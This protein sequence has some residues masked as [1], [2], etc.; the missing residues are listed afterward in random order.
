ML[1]T[2][3][4]ITGFYGPEH[5][6]NG[7]LMRTVLFD[8]DGVFGLYGQDLARGSNTQM[9]YLTKFIDAKYQRIIHVRNLQHKGSGPQAGNQKRL[10]FTLAGVSR[11]LFHLDTEWAQKYVDEIHDVIIPQLMTY[12]VVHLEEGMI[13]N[14]FADSFYL[15]GNAQQTNSGLYVMKNTVEV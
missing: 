6:L 7:R 5:S 14:E 1:D 4:E 12:R 2:T 9:S 15:L 8:N 10:F 11:F 13:M 3:T